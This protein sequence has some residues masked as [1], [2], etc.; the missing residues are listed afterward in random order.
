MALSA[1]LADPD[2][3]VGSHA[4]LSGNGSSVCFSGTTAAGVRSNVALAPGPDQFAY[5][6]VKRWTSLGVVFGISGSAAATPATGSAPA[7][8]D[9][10]MV[11]FSNSLM[12]SAAGNVSLG[13]VGTGDTFGF[14]V[15]YRAK[16]PVVYVIGPAS[17]NPGACAGIPALDPCVLERKQIETVTGQLFFYAHST[18][19]GSVGVKVSINT[20]GDLVNK[21]YKYVSPKV[22][23]A[24]NAAWFEGDRGLNPQWPGTTGLVPQPTLSINGHAQVVARQGDTNPFRT[25]LSVTPSTTGSTVVWS[26]AAGTALGTGNTLPLSAALVAGYAPGAQRI[27]ARMNDPATGRTAVAYHRLVVVAASSNDDDDGDGLSYDQEKALGTDPGN[28]DT[29]GD[30]LSDGAEAGWGTS[31]INFDTDGNGVGDGAQLGGG[32]LPL[33]AVLASQFGVTSPGVVVSSDGLSAAFTAD[34]NQD[35]VQQLGAFA[36]PLFELERCKKRAV[37]ANVGVQSGEFRYFETQR[38]G[39]TENLGHGVVSGGGALDPYC[40][41]VVGAT[42]PSAVTPPSLSVNSAGG[43]FVN[44]VQGGASFSPPSQLGLSTHYGFVVDYRGPQPVVYVV[45]TSAAGEMTVSSAITLQGLGGGELFPMLY[46]HPNLNKAAR[47]TVNLGLGAFHYSTT[48]IQAALVAKGV[49]T[50]NFVPGVGLH[51]WKLP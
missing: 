10:V 45:M 38:L 12:T 32:G 2:G 41:F 43:L 31:P 17:V 7:R 11:D 36:D 5:I 21:P 44:L 4:W 29:D 35:C 20:G 51:R 33:K 18:G 23:E 34:L 3:S 9:A 50:V 13:N 16:Y 42:T 30:G 1:K 48:A 8:P 46:G 27:T 15:D 40:C 14:A 26:D 49:S 24:L 6:E 22:R 39:P 28:A 25:T 47:S 19:D 37:R